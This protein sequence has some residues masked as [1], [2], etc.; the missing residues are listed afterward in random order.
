MLRLLRMFL[1]VAFGLS[2]F[3]SM[4]LCAEEKL[5][6]DSPRHRSHKR[7]HLSQEALAEEIDTLRTEMREQ[8]AVMRQAIAERDA[9]I[10]TLEAGLHERPAAPVETFNARL[11]STLPIAAPEHAVYATTQPAEAAAVAPVATL[12]QK[13]Q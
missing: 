1:I 8:M 3:S 5:E 2:F 11:E 6:D 4:D 7:A 13:P 9:R 10:V 12:A